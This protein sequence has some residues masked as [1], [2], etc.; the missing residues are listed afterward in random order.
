MR[1]TTVIAAAVILVGAVVIVRWMPGKPKV[2]MDEVIAAEV[3]A[4]VA[5]A[6]RELAALRRLE[7]LGSLEGSRSVGIP[8]AQRALHARTER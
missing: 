5:K 7:P 2:N 1:I 3:A 8:A 6:E 4:E